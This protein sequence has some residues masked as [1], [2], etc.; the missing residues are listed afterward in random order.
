MSKKNN[1]Y[2]E[3]SII[4]E[5]PREF[6]RRVP[7]TYLG[8]SR[9][10]SNLIKEVVANAV[11][12]FVIGHCDNIKIKI[13]TKKNSYIVE[14]NG[15]GFL[16]NAGIDQDGKTI[17]QRSFDTI[18]TS[19]KTSE[20][21]VYQ[22]TALGLNGIGAKI[23]NWLSISLHVKT[24]RDNEYEEIWFK[25]GLFDKRE[26]G[27]EEH[28]SGTIVEWSPDP[29]FF[30]VNAPDIEYLKTYFEEISALCPELTI[31]L[32]YNGSDFI[33]HTPEGLDALMSK[34]V[35]NKELFSNRFIISREL[36]KDKLNI[37]L[38]YTTDYSDNITAYVNLGHTDSGMHLSAMKTAFV[39]AVNKYASENNLLKKKDK[40]FSSNEIS[41]GLN[42]IFNMTTT[43]A[44]YDAQ[45]KS[46]IDDIDA[47]II[48][49]VMSG[50]FATWLSNNPSEAAIIVERALNSR[51][52]R[53][54]AKKAKDKIRGVSK[55]SNSLFIDMPTKLA[56]A[57]P[58][59][60]KD[61][62][63][64]ELYVCLK[65]DTK[66]RLLDG[67]NEEIQNLVN[68]NDIWI[69]SSNKN[70]S[71]IPVKM[72]NA[73]ATKKV[74]QTLKITFDDGSSV[75]C[76]P[77]HKFLDRETHEWVEAKDLSIYQSLVSIKSKIIDNR[78][79]IF[80]PNG[81]DYSGEVNDLKFYKGRWEATHRRVAEL[82]GISIHD[83]KLRDIHHKNLNRLD[84]R[85]E[86]LESLTKGDHLAK[87]N[88]INHDS[89]RMDYEKKNFTEESRWRMQNGS[90]FRTKEG[91]IQYSKKIKEAWKNGCYGEHCTWSRY[92]T[93]ERFTE[94]G[95]D[96][97]AICRLL[98]YGKFILTKTDEI[99]KETWNAYKKEYCDKYNLRFVLSFETLVKYY[100]DLDQ[101]KQD[102]ENYNLEVIS[103]EEKQYDV[104]VQMYCLNVD[105]DFHAFVLDN[106]LVTHNCEGNSASS[107]ITATRDASKIAV[108]PIRGKI[109]NCMKASLDKV[110]AN[111][112]IADITRA[113]GLDVD[114][115]T[116][117]LIYNPKKLRYNKIVIATDA[118]ADAS[119]ITMLLCTV[120]DWLCPELFTNGHIYKVYGALFKVTFPDNSYLLF[121]NDK[122]FNEWKENNKDL[123]YK[124]ARAKGLGEMTAEE[125]FE[126]LVNEETRNLKMIT[127]E[128]YEEFEKYLNI[129]EGADV[130]AR[131][132]Y[133]EKYYE[134]RESNN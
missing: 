67:T 75:E 87:H 65:G 45:N 71:M 41:E 35:T 127:T 77:E 40:N 18:N 59:N 44:K 39:K 133:L 108:L 68:K 25:D 86:N 111:Q 93:K 37:C 57:Y 6:T 3:N 94:D 74:Y 119:S 107:S 47:T 56:D 16:V 51:K 123:K 7:S 122:E 48:N 27:K 38:T 120:F 70:G 23:T 80:I 132:E 64:C 54:A 110:Y 130:T 78:E 103:I 32:N 30:K 21:G 11:D 61:R 22:G 14:D 106:G 104:P 101:F 85:P 26:V 121:A 15:Q 114:K 43:T 117:K 113:L 53:E 8:S 20:D 83:N 88:R 102:A 60:K 17:L 50:D 46:R 95:K 126:Q 112:E 91:S 1:L 131:K 100:N 109:L 89:G 10:N 12:E 98:K 82:C 72:K 19:G 31:E 36:G 128:D 5:S 62:S 92:N 66:V 73:F 58:K 24:Y 13:D 116:G 84:N 81:L 34:R 115:D 76:T 97:T 124:V 49:N 69:Y 55:K 129:F 79:S 4:S 28:S 134:E 52:A 29:Q 9:H 99:N 63:Q 125:T 105:N 42:I 33:Y 90:K 118:D 2:D 96:K